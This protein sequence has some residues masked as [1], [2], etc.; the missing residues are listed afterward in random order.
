MDFFWKAH[1]GHSPILNYLD[2]L[3]E[4]M[5]AGRSGMGLNDG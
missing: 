3:Q 2:K 4:L 5:M 1:I